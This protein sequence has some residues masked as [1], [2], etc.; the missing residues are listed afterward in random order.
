MVLYS[1]IK[2]TMQTFPGDVYM[3]LGVLLQDAAAIARDPSVSTDEKEGLF[4]LQVNCGN[5][6]HFRFGYTLHGVPS[7]VDGACPA[8][9]LMLVENVLRRDSATR[10]IVWRRARHEFW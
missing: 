10:G 1:V 3:H 7:H 2:S 8:G 9:T 5:T 4:W 6:M